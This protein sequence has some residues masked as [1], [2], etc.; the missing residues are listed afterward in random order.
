MLW[1][2]VEPFSGN[3]RRPCDVE[4]LLVPAKFSAAVFFEVSFSARSSALQ[5]AFQKLM[6]NKKGGHVIG[7][8]GSPGISHG[9]SRSKVNG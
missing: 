8:G 5:P 1:S 9:S 4:N 3:R 2:Q 7:A 6:N